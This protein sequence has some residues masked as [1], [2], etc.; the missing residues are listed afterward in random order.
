MITMVR[1]LIPFIPDKYKHTPNHTK[2]KLSLGNAAVRS[3]D[4]VTTVENAHRKCHKAF[5]KVDNYAT[6]IL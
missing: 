5:E 1:Q 3:L 2:G 6:S 4:E